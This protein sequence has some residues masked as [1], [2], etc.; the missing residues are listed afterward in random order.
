MPDPLLALL[1]DTT[2]FHDK[3]AA[4]VGALGIDTRPM[5]LSH[6]CVRVGTMDAYRSLR[7]GLISVGEGYTEND[8]NGR[9]VSLI[10]LRDKPRLGGKVFALVE[11]PAPRAAHEYADGLE[12]VGWV[13]AGPFGDFFDNHRAV[14]SGIKD[15]GEDF[16]PAFISF[17]DGA[18]AKFYPKPLREVV[19]AEGGV[20]RAVG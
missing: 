15:R 11:L 7:D 8:F 4:R 1:G 10:E 19:E 5:S 12:H 9:P 6:L 18:T 3:L 16:Q 17:D 13:V 2:A 20:F 14:L